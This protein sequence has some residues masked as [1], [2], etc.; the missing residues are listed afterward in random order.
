[1]Q[2]EQ[3]P[4]GKFGG[5]STTRSDYPRH[6]IAAAPAAVVPTVDASRPRPKMD[7]T[8]S[9]I[10]MLPNLTLQ[11]SDYKPFTAAPSEAVRPAGSQVQLEQDRT[12]RFLSYARLMSDLKPPVETMGNKMAPP[13]L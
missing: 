4:A 7:F 8:T 9:V 2:L 13:P 3:D 1:M 12:S 5:A 10:L 11:S 6:D